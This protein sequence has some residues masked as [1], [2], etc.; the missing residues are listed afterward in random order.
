MRRP[1]ILALLPLAVA[2]AKPKQAPGIVPADAPFTFGR[3]ERDGRAVE[4]PV[5][6]EISWPPDGGATVYLEGGIAQIRLFSQSAAGVNVNDQ[7]VARFFKKSLGRP[8]G[9][10]MEEERKGVKIY[11]QASEP[12]VRGSLRLRHAACLRVDAETRSDAVVTMAVF[13][14]PE[15]R[16]EPLGGARVCAEILRS[17]RGFRPQ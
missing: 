5:G 16:F 8:R 15:D 1:L 10:L 3:I 12:V 2:C 7:D 14:A 4:A 11:C 17:A 6:A 9:P 13:G